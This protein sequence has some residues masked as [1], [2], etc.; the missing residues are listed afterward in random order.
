MFKKAIQLVTFLVIAFGFIAGASA[1][2]S[3]AT[4]VVYHIDDAELQGIKG[5][6]NIRN[7]LDTAPNTTIIVVS[8]DGQLLKSADQH[9]HLQNGTL[10]IL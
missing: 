7:H 6:R 2:S 9:L 8:A 4:K 1:Q 10:D 3:G 5:L